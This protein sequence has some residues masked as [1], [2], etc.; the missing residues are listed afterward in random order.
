ML[1][2]L[3]EA[4]KNFGVHPDTLRRW[5]KAGKISF[6]LSAGGHRLFD[7]SEISE[8]LK[9]PSGRIVTKGKPT[10][11]YARV[12]SHDQKADLKR[13]IETLSLFCSANGWEH[14]IISDLGSGM[15]YQKKVLKISSALYAIR[16]LA[17]LSSPTKTGFC[18]S[19]RS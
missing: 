12:S 9:M 3:S 14:E 10:I 1:L 6:S 15:N 13:Q 4:A 11:G 5:A 17:D 16:K 2:R 7:S 8:F 18:A 19:V